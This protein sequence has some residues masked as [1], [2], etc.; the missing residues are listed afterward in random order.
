MNTTHQPTAHQICVTAPDAEAA[1]QRLAAEGYNRIPVTLEALAEFGFVDV[2]VC[3]LMLRY[4]KTD[5]K[6]VRPEDQ[7]IGHT[8]FLIF[9]IKT[10]PYG[11]N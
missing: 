8:G 5:P 4:Y 2:K 3:E 11:E 6:R 9:G 10:L 1:F 7:M